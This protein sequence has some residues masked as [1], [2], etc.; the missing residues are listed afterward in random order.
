MK[1]RSAKPTKKVMAGGITGLIASVLIYAA[2]SVWHIALPTE[3]ATALAGIVVAVVGWLA[4]YLTPAAP[5]DAPVP[6]ARRR[7]DPVSH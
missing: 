7:R 2:L 3:V 5:E 1:Q 4:A 6:A